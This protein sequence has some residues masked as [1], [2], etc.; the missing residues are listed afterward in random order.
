MEFYGSR[1]A[2]KRYRSEPVIVSTEFYDY[3]GEND[4]DSSGA[5][6]STNYRVM[7]ITYDDCTPAYNSAAI[8]GADDCYNIQNY[9]SNVVLP[10]QACIEIYNNKLPKHVHYGGQQHIPPPHPH[11]QHGM[12]PQQPYPA[13]QQQQPPNQFM[14]DA[15]GRRT[16]M[17]GVGAAQNPDY[18]SGGED[19]II[20]N[21]RQV[22][23]HCGCC[24][25]QNG[26]YPAGQPIQ[27]QYRVDRPGRYDFRGG[28]KPVKFFRYFNIKISYL[29]LILKVRTILFIFYLL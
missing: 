6:S 8:N 14:V 21:V 1:Y 25:G 11:Q 26:G 24:R 20:I 18:S 28:E 29:S 22:P 16:P 27:Q 5:G 15:A 17:N 19:E 12:Y 7:P 3:T 23:M 2:P 9:G 4:C 13:Q 10:F